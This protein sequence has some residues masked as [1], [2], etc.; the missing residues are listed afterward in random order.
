[1]APQ[2]K[3]DLFEESIGSWL[4][5]QG[6]M[7]SA[8]EGDE[9]GPRDAGG[10]L[11]SGLEGNHLVSPHMHDKSRRLHFGQKVGDIKIAN[12]IEISCS[13]LWRGRFQLQV[14]DIICLLLRCA[15]N[16]SS[17]EHLL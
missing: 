6:Q 10:Q 13:V 9:T 4:V 12:D 1:S 5:F 2:E 14:V 17:G 11:A 8:G 16:E 3:A 15:W 7:V